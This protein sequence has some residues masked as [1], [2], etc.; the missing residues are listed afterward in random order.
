M[1]LHVFHLN[2]EVVVVGERD[3]GEEG[4]VHMVDEPIGYITVQFFGGVLRRYKPEEL[5]H[6]PKYPTKTC[7][8]EMKG[9]E[10][11]CFL[12]LAWCSAKEKSLCSSYQPYV[13]HT[14]N[15]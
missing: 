1:V 8:Q 11:R 10:G 7:V 6:K 14:E 15:E 12:K 9:N 2:D 3:K 5:N 4:F 13:P